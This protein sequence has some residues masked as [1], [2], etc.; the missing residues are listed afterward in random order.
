MIVSMLLDREA[1]KDR[2]SMSLQRSSVPSIPPE[3]VWV[4]K[5]SFPSGNVYMQMR[6]EL[7]PSMMMNCLQVSTRKSGNPRLRAFCLALVSVMQFAENLSDRQAAEAV[8]A[9]IDWK[10]ALSLPLNESGFHSSVRSRISG[11]EARKA[12]W[13]A[14]CWI[15]S[16]ISGSLEAIFAPVGGNEP[17]PRMC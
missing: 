1:R 5:A 8:R 17:I 2:T 12:V 14:S 9:R 3:T 11:P 4:A 10:Y 13:K 16:L 15:P 7:E 6:D